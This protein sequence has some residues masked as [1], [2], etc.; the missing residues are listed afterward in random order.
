MTRNLPTALR[1]QGFVAQRVMSAACLSCR[2]VNVREASPS[3]RCSCK[4]KQVTVGPTLLW[5]YQY[6]N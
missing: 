4:N 1:R 2:A 5:R 3:P 6:G